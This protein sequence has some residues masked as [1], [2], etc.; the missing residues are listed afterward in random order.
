MANNTTTNSHI[1]SLIDYVLDVKPYHVKLAGGVEEYVFH[2]DSLNVSIDES[3]ETMVVIGPDYNNASNNVARKV[4]AN[5]SPRPL[6]TTSTTRIVQSDGQRR[7]YSIPAVLFNKTGSETGNVFTKVITSAPTE[8]P[9]LVAGLFDTRAFYPNYGNI[10]SVKKN[11]VTLVKNVDY[12]VS[13][14]AFSFNVAV[15]ASR[16]WKQHNLVDVP[17]IP[18]TE[19]V[20]AF[21]DVVRKFGTVKDIVVDADAAV[22][23]EWTITYASETTVN[24]IGSASGH[25]GVATFDTPFVHAAISFTYTANTGEELIPVMQD[26]DE[27][28]LTPTSKICIHADATEQTWTLI[29]AGGFYKV[30]GSVS[31]FAADAYVGE[32]YDNE[33]I[34][35]KIPK[36]E[37]W[38]YVNGET[39]DTAA[40]TDKTIYTSCQNLLLD[41]SFALNNTQDLDGNYDPLDATP[42]VYTI[43]FR[44]GTP[45]AGAVHSASVFNNVRGYRRG[46]ENGVAWNDG[47]LTVETS[48]NWVAGDEIKVVLAPQGWQTWFGGY[49]EAPYE[50]TLYDMGTAER[51]IPVDMLK[52]HF[53]LYHS[54][55]AVLVFSPL[56]LDGGWMLDGSESLGGSTTLLPGEATPLLLDGGWMLDGSETLDGET[57]ILSG[58]VIKIEKAQRDRMRLRFGDGDDLPDALGAEN[59]WIP[60]EYRPNAEVPTFAT[61]LPAYLS[62][63]P[64]T[65]VFTITQPNVGGKPGLASIEF[66]PTFFSDFVTSST[67]MTFE[68]N[69]SDNYGPKVGVN[70]TEELNITINTIPWNLFLD[71]TFD[72]DGSEELDGTANG[73]V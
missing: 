57:Y 62:T 58:D 24:V 16:T 72:L 7:V 17:E 53:P 55:D 65:K 34:A 47:W 13:R 61:S 18:E 36:L 9:G 5:T 32:W 2:E 15:G 49:D 71:G 41:G 60:L 30:F 43:T 51:S 38:V 11:D 44:E 45:T 20:Y 69:Q 3:H 52:P 73:G 67:V 26:G 66:D 48:G 64:T 33:E 19:S 39:I 12:I 25:I 29:N 1:E 50:W 23:E 31:G 63:D 70:L 37:A 6:S 56:M 68:F 59:G 35:F 21:N 8:I 42:S 54:K 22:Y 28:K 10:V 46:L 40:L 14:G 4:W 27:F